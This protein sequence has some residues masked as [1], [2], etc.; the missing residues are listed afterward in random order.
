MWI[1]SDIGIPGNELARGLATIAA[2][3]PDIEICPLVTDE[4]LIH[5]LKIERDFPRH[6]QWEKRINKQT[7]RQTSKSTKFKIVNQNII[8]Y[9]P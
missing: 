5:T 3:P 6:A 2:K 9:V 8:I 4:N 7:N 1:P